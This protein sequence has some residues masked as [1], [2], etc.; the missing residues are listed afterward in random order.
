MGSYLL[1]TLE[2]GYIGQGYKVEQ[3]EEALKGRFHF[4]YPVSV[5]SCTSALQL[6]IH[7]AKP[8]YYYD[9]IEVL[10][11]P[12]TCFA[13]TAAILANGL[14][15]TWVD[16]DPLT[17]NMDLDHLDHKLSRNTHIIVVVH[18]GGYP[19]NLDRLSVILDKCEMRYGHRPIVIEDCAHAL[20]S[21]YQGHMIGTSDNLCCFS[22]QA[23]K[24]LTTG[25]G[26][27]L[28]VPD[29]S[30]YERAKLLR[31]F[32]MDRNA[33]RTDDIPEA[34][35]K[36]HMTDLNASIGLANLEHINKLL[37]RQRENCEYYIKELPDISRPE[38][39]GD[40]P[41][42]WLFPIMVDRV[43]D[44]RWYME[45]LGVESTPAHYRNDKYSCVADRADDL[46]QM[47]VIEKEMTCIP[48]GWW[49]TDEDREFIV[50]AIRKG[51]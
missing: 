34:G 35:F 50:S 51:W 11:T 4:R 10:T 48:C 17:L 27:L 49:V 32:G 37:R 33:P 21:Y 1:P 44:F 30:L 15:P 36:Y 24:T 5:N 9:E 6:A 39:E 13:T 41:N 47:D 46:P 19:I 16:V 45:G 23:V 25:D 31:W 14:R 43:Q 8:T 7:L 2:S 3:F 42:G 18:F 29:Y 22:F 20:S 28:S 40:C 12:L 26:G 38:R